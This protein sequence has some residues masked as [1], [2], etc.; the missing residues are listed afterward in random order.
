MSAVCSRLILTG[1]NKVTGYSSMQ[2]A[3]TLSTGTHMP[4][5]ITQC[6]L[7][8]GRGNIPAF[9]QPSLVLDLATRADSRLSWPIM[10]Y[11]EMYVA[12]TGNSW[13]YMPLRKNSDFVSTL[14]KES[15]LKFTSGSF[16]MASNRVRFTMVAVCSSVSGRPRNSAI[17]LTVSAGFYFDTQTHNNHYTVSQLK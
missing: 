17:F 5:G 7:P 6:Y 3:S 10:L 4:Y 13:K 1:N 16:F 14:T 9:T 8:S 2:Q 11:N 15:C 12:K